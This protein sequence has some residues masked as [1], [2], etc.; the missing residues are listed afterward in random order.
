MPMLDRFNLSTLSA[1]VAGAVV[2][3]TYL[4]SDISVPAR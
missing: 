3:S 1:M 4:V 2:E